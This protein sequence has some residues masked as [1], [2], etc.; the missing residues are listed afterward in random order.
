MEGFTS[1]LFCMWYRSLSQ[2]VLLYMWGW[3]WLGLLYCIP[4]K[5]CCKIQLPRKLL[6]LTF[7]KIHKHYTV[8][9]VAFKQRGLCQCFTTYLFP[10]VHSQRDISKQGREYC[11]IFKVE[12]DTTTL[13]VKKYNQL[14]I[15]NVC[16]YF[17][18]DL[19]FAQWRMLGECSYEMWC[20]AVW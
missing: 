13:P 10:L 20:S 16:R 12:N 19:K 14:H 5:Y 11:T 18:S 9:N 6:H 8:L 1:D 3:G 15:Q 7:Y 17:R 2:T 4:L